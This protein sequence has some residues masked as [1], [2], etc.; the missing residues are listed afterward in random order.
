VLAAAALG[1]GVGGGGADHQAV[2][3][4]VAQRPGQHLDPVHVRGGGV[5]LGD[6]APGVVAVD[7]P[8]AEVGGRVQDRAG[9]DRRPAQLEPAGEVVVEQLALR[10]RVAA[11]RAD[12]KSAPRR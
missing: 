5:Q 1:E 12:R 9:V 11:A 6:G 8:L 3:E 7:Q 2:A 10:G 4:L